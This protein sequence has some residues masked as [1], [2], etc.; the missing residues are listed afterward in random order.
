M[1]WIVRCILIMLFLAWATAFAQEWELGA[2]GGFG[3]SRNPGVT[4]AA[5]SAGTAGLKQGPAAGVVVGNNLYERVS[6]ELHY[7][8]RSSNLK[9]TGGGQEAGFGGESHIVH[10]DLLYHTANRDERIRPFIAGGAGLRYYRGTGVETA[11][12]PAAKFALLTK[13]QQLKPL[14]SVGGGVKVAVSDSM[15]LRV[16]VRDYVT[17]F[18][19]DVIAPAPGAKL[20]GWLHDFVPMVGI[21]VRF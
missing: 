10:Y 19:K 12:Q 17:P 9:T 15:Y 14:V 13:T 5:G 6:G 16:E 4:S 7:V 20:K 8:Y 11:F 21:G 18:P 2:H 1:Q 3:F